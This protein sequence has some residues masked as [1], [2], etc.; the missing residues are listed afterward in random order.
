MFAR[1]RALLLP[2]TVAALC[3]AA[4]PCALLTAA[5]PGSAALPQRLSSPPEKI[6]IFGVDAGD[7]RVID[8]LV[9]AGQ[10]PCFARLKQVGATGVLQPEPPLLSPI[11]WTTMATGR[12]PEDHGV[13]DFMVDRP[14][15]GQAPV[16]GG[17]RR[18][19][20]LWE[21]WSEAGRRVLV[22]GWWA[23]WPA[24]R[25]RG[26]IVSDRLATPHFA[27]ST[28][29]DAGLVFPAT[30]L[31]DVTRL[32]VEPQALDYQAVA[33]LIPVTRAEFDRAQGITRES[34]GGLYRDRIAHFRA[35]VAAARTYR[36]VSTELAKSVAPDFWAVY[37][38]VVDTTSHLFLADPA[39]R[40][41]AVAAAYRE[42]D[43]ALADTARVLDP[44]TLLLVVSD[45][46]FQPP[47]AGIR[48]DPSDL[49][50]GAT[51]WHRPYGIIAAVEAGAL[52]GTLAPRPLAPLGTVSPLDIAPTVLARA[53]L[54]V[55][56]DMPG[57]VI[58]ALAAATPPSRIASYG[59]HVLPEAAAQSHAVAAAEVERL[60]ALGYV[61]GAAAVTSLSRVNL[62]EI[63]YRKGDVAGAA[64]ELEAVLRAEPLNT[65]AAL[66]L[67]RA[68][69]GLKRPDAAVALYDRLVQAAVT[70]S[71]SLDPVVVP[72]ATDLD[73]AAGRLEA[74]AARLRRLP[75]AILATPEARLAA[76]AVAEAQGRAAAAERA[77]RQAL[78]A[79]PSDFDALQ[80]LLDLLLRQK[81]VEEAIAATA[82]AAR[83]FPA[84]PQHLSLAGEAALSARRYAQAER[85][86]FQALA[87]APTAAA[88]R[89]DLAR[90]QLQGGRPDAAMETLRDAGEAREVDMLRGA[91]LSARRDWRSAV[92][93]FQRAL[94][95]GP[96][97]AD[98]LTSLAA[99]QL[100]AG[101]RGDAVRSLEQSLSLEPNQPAARALLQRAR[102]Q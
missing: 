46:G 38:E 1:G 33:R 97:R 92:A 63:L 22:T 48:E 71:F 68:Y 23:T 8:G 17:A 80:R 73:L 40:D 57:R 62:G 88:V 50:A 15:G 81:R 27:D 18:V 79:S 6:A 10:L 90:S 24:D 7:W 89:I 45:H 99:A 54:A 51:A 30:A 12:R 47:D 98:L 74:A 34:A 72:A 69:V 96:P 65:H 3:L 43:D 13:L 64:R 20:A 86:F 36:R 102:N 77:Y 61:S 66:W 87:L 28:R 95:A 4:S 44:H 49:T 2:W 31:A 5:G 76:G 35:V 25:V 75:A 83:A 52:A 53:G 60:R 11:I 91:A 78:A 93:A 58:P 29:P 55:A 19:K 82:S 32:V 41:R 101:M 85:Y 39:R 42:V 21:I 84:S 16:T 14:G 70:T 94:A 26:V 9:A 67:A 56:A 59:A 37:Y 100:E